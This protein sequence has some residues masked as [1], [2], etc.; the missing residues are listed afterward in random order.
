[1][2]SKKIDFFKVNFGIA[3]GLILVLILNYFFPVSRI[4]DSLL[5]M[6]GVLATIPIFISSIKA[7]KEKK[8]SVDLLAAIALLVSLLNQEW[9]SVAFINLMITSA[10][11]FGLYTENKARLAIESLLK[12]KPKTVKIKFKNT[13]IEKDLE[14]VQKGDVVI[15]EQGERIPV[16]GKVISGM[17]SIDQS[18]LTG[19]SIPIS[20]NKGDKV[21]SST[22]NING[23][24][25]V[26]AE[27]VGKD[28]ALEKIIKLVENAQNDKVLIKTISERFASWYILITFV[29]AILIFVFS[30]NINLVLSVLL[31]TCADDI[32]VATPLAFWAA[33]GHAAKRGIIIKGAS[34]LEGLTKVK[35]LIVDKT[36]TLT[37]GKIKVIHIVSFDKSSPEELIKLAA[38]AES[39]SEHPVAKAIINQADLF[40]IKVE[41]PNEFREIMGKGVV[42]ENINRKIITG[43]LLLIRD[44]KI[45]VNNYQ[46]KRIDEFE[47][48]G[49]NIVL[50]ASDDKLLGL[51]ALG[52]G[53]RYGIKKTVE[54][55]KNIGIDRIVMLTGDNFEVAQRVAREIGISEFHA[56]F[57]PKDK[58]EFVKQHLTKK[59][60]IAM[61]GDGVNDAAALALADVG[62]AMGVIGSDTAI[63]A[64]DVALM[65]D[66]FNKIAESILIG[67]FVLKVAMENFII[68]GT[69]N[70]LGLILVFTKTI[71]PE[72]A[73]AYNFFTDFLPLINSVRLFKYHHRQLNP[74][75]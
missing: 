14:L 3:A 31:V 36:G 11:I 66:D 15:I 32:A 48:D 75:D 13:I 26:L 2:F 6:I 25:V 69:V 74:K 9:T 63:E 23:S 12:L 57:L 30:K 41:A 58:L 53:L 56:N 62:I 35:M 47:R 19:E 70:I 60:K 5:I 65:N 61:V 33:I 50:V 17:A 55:L 52:D 20:K 49:H 10:R 7:L 54:R 24:L 43:N 73:A 27:K 21:F 68:W 34:F 16:D 8:I 71:G 22:L 64:A 18:S 44:Q 67:K 51:I 28:T 45:K 39:V 37:R 38:I 40:G 46:L 42:A 4:I 72:G 29:G 59:N 1:M